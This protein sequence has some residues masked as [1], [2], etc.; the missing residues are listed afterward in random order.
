MKHTKRILIK[1]VIIS[2]VLLSTIITACSGFSVNSAAE[3][4]QKQPIQ[5]TTQTIPALRGSTLQDLETEILSQGQHLDSGFS[6]ETDAFS[7]NN[8]GDDPDITNLTPAEIRRMF[9]DQVCARFTPAAS[10]TESNCI[11]TPPAQ[12]FMEEMN[13]LMAN[14]H[15]EGLAVLSVFLQSGILAPVDFGGATTAS[16]TLEDNPTLQR[17]IAYWFT[18]QLTSPTIETI[19]R[20]PPNQILAILAE[21]FEEDASETYTMGI[22]RQ[23]MSDGHSVTPFAIEWQGDDIFW[24]WIYDNN[25]GNIPRHIVF[26]LSENSWSYENALNPESYSDLITGN[27]ETLN[28]DITPNSNRLGLQDCT[29]CHPSQ[30]TNSEASKN[31]NQKFTNQLW[32]ESVNPVMI[33]NDRGDRIGFDGEVF[34]DEMPGSRI[35]S[36]KFANSPTHINPIY[37]LPTDRLYEIFLDGSQVTPSEDPTRVVMLGQG[38]YIGIKNIIQTPGESHKITLSE[39]AQTLIFE[40]GG[41]VQPSFII[42]FEDDPMDYEMTVASVAMTPGSLVAITF[43]PEKGWLTLSTSQSEGHQIDVEITCIYRYGV[44]TFWG[45]QIKLASSDLIHFDIS[46]WWQNG[47]GKMQVHID[48]SEDGTIDQTLELENIN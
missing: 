8:Y 19:L 39:D 22:Y 6:P 41:E 14:G 4:Y 10:E 40:A 15:C 38:F 48:K 18:T 21:S 2:L 43:D 5:T 3:T 44:E 36:L 33:Q 42:G 27:A 12:Q 20:L 30:Q 13:A 1:S 32:V 31:D 28:L 29:F 45:E 16:L 47:Y 35:T 34:I 24:L 46:D 9:G 11:L 23:D 37:H 7:F 17:E 25:F 26:D